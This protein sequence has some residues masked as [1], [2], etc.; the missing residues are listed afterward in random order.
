MSSPRSRLGLEDADHLLGVALELDELGAAQDEVE[1]CLPEAAAADEADVLHAH[2]QAGA[3]HAPAH[4]LHQ[5]DLA[6]RRWE[7]CWSPT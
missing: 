3:G 7:R 6:P 5:L 2:P 1:R 4:V